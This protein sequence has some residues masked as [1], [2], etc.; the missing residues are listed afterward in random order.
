MI[1]FEIT[2][3]SWTMLDQLLIPKPNNCLR[4]AFQGGA[5][6]KIRGLEVCSLKRFGEATQIPKLERVR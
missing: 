4:I 1:V 5:Y 3:L 2:V 6:K